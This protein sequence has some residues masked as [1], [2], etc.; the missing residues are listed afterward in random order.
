MYVL[1]RLLF[2]FEVLVENFNE[3]DKF[4]QVLTQ[5]DCKP[6]EEHFKY[7]GCGRR[8]PEKSALF[9]ALILK[10]LMGLITTKSLVSCL[11]YSP[12]LAYWCGF[13]V[14][15]RIPSESTFSRFETKMTDP[16]LQGALN[17]ICEDLSAKLLSITGSTAQV[18][19]DSTDIPAHENP[20]KEST[21]G[22][23]F[24]HRTASTGETEMFYGYKLH[25]AAVNT[26]MGPVPVAARVAPANCSDVNP[27]FITNIMKEACEFHNNVLGYNP[28]YYIMDAGYDAGSIY[29]QALELKGQAIV[30]LNRRGRKN[31]SSEY[32]DDGTPYC[33]A[34]NPMSY[35]GTDHKRL[36]NKFRC[37]RKCGQDVTCHNECGCENPYG[38]FKRLSTKENPRM[39]CIPHRGSRNWKKLYSTRSSIERLFSVLKG[40]LNMDRLTKRGLEKAFTDVMICLITFLAGTIVQLKKQME[41]KVA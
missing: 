6:F 8:G 31:S 24:G 20:F 37:P 5:I 25:L 4:Y 38:Y 34:G 18:V 23:S 1:D 40:H 36:V 22:A 7:K 16:L 32:T 12:Q 21:T 41:Q 33:P 15:G 28:Y 2:P 11:S 13:N 39:F 3:E 27:E 35:Y 26:D 19:I 17:N 14:L 9:K 10:R 30:K 29:S